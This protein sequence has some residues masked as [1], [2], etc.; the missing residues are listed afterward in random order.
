MYFHDGAAVW[1]PL[2]DPL[3][4]CSAPGD[5]PCAY[6]LDGANVAEVIRLG[7]GR[8]VVM[9]AIDVPGADSCEVQINR[10]RD[11]VPQG[12]DINPAGCGLTL[13]EAQNYVRFIITELKPHIDAQYRTLTDREHTGVAGASLGGLCSMYMGWDFGD[14]LYPD[15]FFGLPA[16]FARVGSGSGSYQ[17]GDS[18]AARVVN[19]KEPK[20]EIR[21]YQD[22]GAPFDLYNVN[23]AFRDE[24][25]SKSPE[26]YVVE[27][28]HRWFVGFGQAHTIQE[29]GSRWPNMVTFLFPGTEEPNELLCTADLDC[30]GNVGITDFLALLAAWGTPDGDIDGD[31]TT[32]IVDFLLLLANWGPCL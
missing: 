2:V 23:T 18:F 31:G 22:T 7:Q 32:G 4:P 9:V 25:L 24:L 8:E 13:G 19:V 12:D 14:P 17:H 10:A 1:D 21:I 11:Y 20:R 30:D 29:I 28:D 3:A 16:T 6:D 27:G 15:P 26:P 5:P